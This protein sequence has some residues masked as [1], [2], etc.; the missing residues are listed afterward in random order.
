MVVQGS[1][2]HKN[3]SGQALSKSQVQP[4]LSEKGLHQDVIVNYLFNCQLI[5][6]VVSSKLPL[7]QII[8]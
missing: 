8:L 1:Q 5:A 2:D 4:I 7:F 3:G 6:Y